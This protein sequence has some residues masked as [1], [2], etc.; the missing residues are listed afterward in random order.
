MTRV[1]DSSSKNVSWLKFLDTGI[2][3]AST[4]LNILI[5][6]RNCR[7]SF[8]TDQNAELHKTPLR[9]NASPFLAILLYTITHIS[10]Y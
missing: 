4:S 3:I 2:S 6:S 8:N 9:K 7:I 10:A 5:L 1:L